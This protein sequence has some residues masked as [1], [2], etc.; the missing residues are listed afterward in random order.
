VL[1]TQAE[2]HAAFDIYVKTKVAEEK[3]AKRALAKIQLEEFKKMMEEV[4]AVQAASNFSHVNSSAATVSTEDT[5]QAQTPSNEPSEAVKP[6]FTHKTTYDDLKRVCG[7]DPRW[8][9]LD[10]KERE[11]LLAEKLAPLKQANARGMWC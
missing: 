3:Q 11:T 2:R 1:T 7:E 4:A 8:L 6:F 10:S 9:A 5:P